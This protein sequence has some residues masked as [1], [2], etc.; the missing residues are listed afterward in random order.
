MADI[1]ETGARWKPARAEI[2]LDGRRLTLRGRQAEL[3][4]RIA[5][6]G[7]VTAADFPPGARVSSYVHK[8]RGKGVPIITD[9]ELTR[10][11]DC[12]FGRYRFGGPVALVSYQPG[13]RV[14]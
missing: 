5:R 2:D 10:R 6:A 4:Q 12:A 11:G 3:V 1:A 14:S 7:S 13:E 9:R 8:A